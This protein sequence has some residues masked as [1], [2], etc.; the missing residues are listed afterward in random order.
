MILLYCVAQLV[1]AFVASFSGWSELKTLYKS[2]DIIINSANRMNGELKLG[3]IR[4]SRDTVAVYD[5][6]DTLVIRG[7]NI[8]LAL[9]FMHFP[10]LSIPRSRIE[11]AAGKTGLLIEC[12][13]NVKVYFE[14]IQDE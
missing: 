12:K 13:N 9:G 1:L 5:Y 8:D 4:F 3:K 14:M 6:A 2:D 10:N 7:P 11:H